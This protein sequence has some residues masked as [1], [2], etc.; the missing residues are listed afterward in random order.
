M[1]ISGRPASFVESARQ[2]V[3]F[4]L[5]EILIV[6]IILGI[7]AAIL[8]PQFSNA[9]QQSRENMLKEN[10]RMLRM[11]ISVYRAQHRD[12]PPGYDNAGNPSEQAF[13][14][15]M[16]QRSDEDG[17]LSPVQ[18][19]A[20]PFGPYLRSIPEN[21]LSGLSSINMVADGG[22][23]PGAAPGNDGWIYKPG[24]LEV[25]A[26]SPGADIEGVNYYSY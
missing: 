7:L 11:Q 3:G 15:Q 16:T 22:A 13:I 8:I 14:D 18:N 12:E 21:P 6:V 17:N 5:V 1:A 25:R 20:F 19:P 24:D 10:L 9:S 23:M 2:R 26:D 4:T